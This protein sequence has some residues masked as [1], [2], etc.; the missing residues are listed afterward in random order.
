MIIIERK[1]QTLKIFV[2]LVVLFLSLIS[3]AQQITHPLHPFREKKEFIYG[4]DNRRT[5]IHSQ[6]TL[7]YGL[8][9]G[10]DFGKKLRFKVGVSGTPFERGEL[11]DDD[12]I[13]KKN[14]LVFANLGE[15]FDFLIINKFRLTTYFQTGIGRNYFRK[16]D[17]LG[18]ETQSGKDLIVP[19]EVGMHAGYD[20]FSWLRAK[21]GGGWRFVLPS[22]SKDLSGYYI[23]LGFGINSKKLIESYTNRKRI[24]TA[25]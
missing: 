8:Y 9:V 21:V 18:I 16:I 3:N 15:E 1:K 4:I 10:V 12:G 13:V 17:S 5:H 20:I 2:L 22:Y 14:R 25:K 6:R 19:I 7:I 11:L 24:T 23:K